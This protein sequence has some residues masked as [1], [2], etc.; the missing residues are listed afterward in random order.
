MRCNNCG[1]EFA[2]GVNFCPICGAPLSSSAE[3]KLSLLVA[4]AGVAVSILALFLPFLKVSIF[5][6]SE[7][8]SLMDGNLRNDGLILIAVLVGGVLLILTGK[9]SKG[10]RNFVVGGIVCL[11]GLVDLFN[12]KSKLSDGSFITVSA[13]IGFYLLMLGGIAIIASGVLRLKNK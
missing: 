13:G 12:N 2:G 6:A 11:I 7:T 3:P 9:N 10:I 5:I 4:L 8:M 1:N